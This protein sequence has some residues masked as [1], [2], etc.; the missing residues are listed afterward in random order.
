[1]TE[2]SDREIIE[3]LLDSDVPEPSPLFWDH[4]SRR[5]SEA[6]AAAPPRRAH[7]RWLSLWGIAAGGAALAMVLLGLAV[8]V[9]SSRVAAP[10]PAAAAI[11]PA[12]EPTA[13]SPG[14][15]DD[16][17]SLAVIAAVASQLDWSEAA[18]LGLSPGSAYRAAAQ[19]SDDERRAVVEM[20][21]EEL[22]RGKDA[23]PL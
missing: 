16:D 14:G 23:R 20:L 15:I 21:R 12:P 1:M 19:L 13:A 22:A 11:S 5:V 7:P 4:L 17:A 18:D 2:R 9:R 3:R 6:V 10:P 8:G